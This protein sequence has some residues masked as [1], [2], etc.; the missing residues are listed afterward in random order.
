MKDTVEIVLFG[1][2]G[3]WLILIPIIMISKI[4]YFRTLRQKKFNGTA[5][6]FSFLSSEW[7][8]AG[9]TW[10]IPI[11][12]CDKSTELNQIKGKANSRLYILY[13]II[14]TQL[15]LVGLLSRLE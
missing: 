3:L 13:F 1:L 5:D 15:I 11:I 2:F 7:W 9:L 10:G 8:I 12:G 4:K 6:L 14:L